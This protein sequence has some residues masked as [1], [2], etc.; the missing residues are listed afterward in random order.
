MQES[1]LVALW[2]F[3]VYFAN[4]K[5]KD[6]VWLKVKTEEKRSEQITINYKP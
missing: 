2:A 1:R 5:I 6:L 3:C 4:S